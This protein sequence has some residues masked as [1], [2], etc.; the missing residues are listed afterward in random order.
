MTRSDAVQHA[1]QYFESGKLQEELAKLVAYQS[2]SQNPA[3]AHVLPQ[4]LTQAIQPCVEATGFICA[5]HDN[6]NS[7]GP[8]LI[9]TRIEDTDLPTVL[10]YGH[11]DVTWGQDDQWRDGLAPF[12]LTQ[13]GERLFGR[14]SADN[15]VQRLINIA[16]LEAVLSVRKRLGFNVKIILETSSANNVSIQ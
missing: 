9:G 14:G 8:F 5:L 1:T 16:A 6:P 12:A 4:Y 10:T 3:Q 11:G 15:K 7:G 13:D 2:E